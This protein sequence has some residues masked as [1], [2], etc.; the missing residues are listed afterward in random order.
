MSSDQATVQFKAS[1]DELLKGIAEATGALQQGFASVTDTVKETSA[2]LEQQLGAAA[3]QT[4]QQIQ[5]L[6]N[7]TR[8]SGDQLDNIAG[9]VDAAFAFAAV[10]KAIEFVKALVAEVQALGATASDILDTAFAFGVTSKEL[11]G[12][13][14]L[15][16]QTGTDF[17]GVNRVLLKLQNTLLEAAQGNR[18]AADELAAFG[19]TAKNFNDETFTSIDAL[20]KVAQSSTNAAEKIQLFGRQNVT[21]LG[22]MEPL[23]RGI[24]GV[25]EAA[26]ETGGAT[27]DQLE[28]LASFNTFMNE[29]SLEAENLKLRL[30]SGTVPALKALF[31][32]LRDLVELKGPLKDILGGA[33]MLLGK[34]IQGLG[35]IVVGVAFI[36][37]TGFEN[38]GIILKGAAEAVIGFAKVWYKF[39]T[40]DFKGAWEEGKKTV[41]G[42]K[43]TYSDLWENI[44]SGSNDAL[45]NAQRFF[46][47]FGGKDGITAPAALDDSEDRPDRG[48]V[49]SK[50]Q[51]KDSYGEEI[52]LQYDLAQAGSEQRIKLANTLVE[53]MARIY[54]Q[55]SEQFRAALRLQFEAVK[56]YNEEQ[57]KLAE[58]RA[59]ATRDGALQELEIE[60]AKMDQQIALGNLTIEEQYALSQQL[61]DRKLAIERAYYEQLKALR[62]EDQVAQEQAQAQLNEAQ[63]QRQQQGIEA[64]TQ[65]IQG[66]RQAWEQALSPISSAFSGAIQGMI[67]GT[68]TLGNAVRKMAL[69]I[70]LSFTDLAIKKTIKWIAGEIAMTQATAGNAAARAALEDAGAKKGIL[71]GAFAALKKIAQFAATAAAGAFQA[72]V[73]I[74]YVGPFLAPAAAVAAGAAVL[75]L[76]RSIAS[77]AGGWVVP[78]D[79]LAMV[80]KD[81]M[82]LPARLS[83]GIQNLIADK[84]EGSGQSNSFAFTVNA[85][86]SGDVGRWFKKNARSIVEAMSEEAGR[87]NPRMAPMSSR[88][89]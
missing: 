14:A 60:K 11:Q 54:G 58:G 3:Q 73:G 65:K 18:D 47:G 38:V 50:R 55:D 13:N 22:I 48:K 5:E 43:E 88:G 80:H 8:N 74:P 44:K 27:R 87:F 4:S 62:A 84:S 39:N 81:E 32:I 83:A 45:L 19:I 68:E 25:G 37:K 10:E 53:R 7:Q 76:G 6:S 33:I 79:Q 61:A 15:A 34:A 1:I 9:K 40:L 29:I 2:A 20:V 89:M 75:A 35:T 77:A 41:L 64:M 28:A 12:L 86:D 78:S 24:K 72:I 69:N 17:D 67:Q 36:I 66:M 31:T 70:L 52:K 30:L 71:S 46:E 56:Q 51:D 59:Q 42:V 85:M 63:Q 26:E 23:K 57:R 16:V 49:K 21:V 82:I